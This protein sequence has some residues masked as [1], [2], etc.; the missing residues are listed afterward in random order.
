VMASICIYNPPYPKDL[1]L[2]CRCVDQG[3]RWA[4]KAYF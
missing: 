2:D 1:G 3:C 4:N